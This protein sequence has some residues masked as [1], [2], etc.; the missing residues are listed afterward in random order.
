VTTATDAVSQGVS[1]TIEDL[2]VRDLSTATLAHVLASRRALEAAG[3]PPPM[4]WERRPRTVE[5]KA[6]RFSKWA[7]SIGAEDDLIGCN[8]FSSLLAKGYAEEAATEV[9][10]DVGVA[11]HRKGDA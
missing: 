8:L 4:E 2:P 5:D 10:R 1:H 11:W 9:L 7:R 3:A 6:W